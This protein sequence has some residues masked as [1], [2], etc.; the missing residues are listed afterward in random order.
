M[1]MF[2]TI[3]N[4]KPSDLANIKDFSE[5]DEG[6]RSYLQIAIHDR[7]DLVPYLLAFDVDINN[8]D[9]RTKSTALHYTLARP[10]RDLAELLLEKGA[11][12]N[13]VDKYGNGALWTAL[14]N[15]AKDYSLVKKIVEKGGDPHHK[16]KVGKSPFDMAV[17]RKEDEIVQYFESNA[18]K[19]R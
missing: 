7:P 1:S 9:L 8:Q 15:A 16:N 14:F 18:L 13:I 10:R 2:L 11:D 4:A 17:T 19:T 12:V 6:G 3:K 5:K